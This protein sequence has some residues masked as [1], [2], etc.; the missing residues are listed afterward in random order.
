MLISKKLKKTFETIEAKVIK[1]IAMSKTNR[2]FY[3]DDDIIKSYEALRAVWL[4]KLSVVRACANFKIS[5]SMYYENEDAFVLNGINGIF[6]EF[7]NCNKLSDLERL[8][9]IVK[10]SRPNLPITGIHRIAEAIPLTNVYTSP[11]TISLIL[12]S[13]GLSPSCRKS[14]YF[15]WSRIQRTLLEIQRVK[16]KKNKSKRD[17]KNKR[18]TFFDDLD[19]SHKRLDLLRELHYNHNAKVPEVCMQYGIAQTSYYRLR[20]DYRL[21]G[22]WA[23]IAAPSYGRDSISEDMELKIILHKR[24]NPS[25]SPQQ[26]VDDLKLKYSRF[27]VNRI[28]K[29]WQLNDCSLAPAAL[30]HYISQ[31]LNAEPVEH[32]GITPAIHLYTDHQLLQ[33]RRQNRHFS[34][35]SK[36]ME[37]HE[38]HICDPGPLILAPFVNDLGIVQSFETHGPERLRGQEMT[39]LAL[40]N[41]F[42]ILAGYRRINHPGDNRDKSVAFASGMGMFG[43]RSRFYGKSID[44]KFPHLQ[45][46]RNDL[47][48]RAKELGL[49]EGIKIAFD[50]HFKEFY[51]KHAKQKGLGKGPDKA[52]N[53]VPGFRPHIAWDVATNA[54]ISIAYYQGAI[55]SS[56]IIRQFCEQNIFPIFNPIAIRELFMD[57]EYTKEGDYQ[58]FKEAIGPTGELYVCLKQNKQIKNLIVP[59]LESNKDWQDYDNGDEIQSSVVELPH[60]RLPFKIVVLRTKDTKD[61]V[62]CFGTTKTSI[63][64][65]ELLQKYR[66]RWTVENGIKDLTQSYFLDETYGIDPEK[67]EFDYYCIMVARLAFEYFMREMGEKYAVKP[68]GNKYALNTVRNILF[69]KRN[70]TLSKN[71]NGNFVLTSIDSGT[72]GW[73]AG[74]KK[75][76]ERWQENKKNKVLWWNNSGLVFETRNQFS[77]IMSCQV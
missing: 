48:A 7:E 73:D 61:E 56:T 57:S 72:E 65:S 26:I 23:I 5:K 52:G 3:I 12:E 6:P 45:A 49:I 13:H 29:K 20:E 39:N 38:I 19:L 1:G 51:G 32:K 55:R 40:L 2:P 50:F 28:I 34:L 43:S 47:V 60:S 15:F 21:F 42:R 30:D 41:V 68:D 67:V 70:C 44:F 54:I 22:P 25:C 24:K 77:E 62:R 11:E 53:L 74:I 10:K 9:I 16:S 33:S 8:V 58:Y 17:R 27:S 59:L 64:D 31:D 76:L 14:D 37:K 66:C 35:I 36:K 46:M 71:S 69:E 63:D 75:V 18:K 4:E